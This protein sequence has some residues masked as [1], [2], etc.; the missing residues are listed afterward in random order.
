VAAAG[1]HFV[2][3]S[4]GGKLQN[5]VDPVLVPEI[6]V[7]SEDVLLPVRCK[8]VLECEVRRQLVSKAI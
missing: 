8:Q 7:H 4:A 5:D 1:E 2:Q 6:T 3:L